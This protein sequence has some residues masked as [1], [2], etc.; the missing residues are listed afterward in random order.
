MKTST[1]AA[2]GL[3]LPSATVAGPEGVDRV[4]DPD[5]RLLPAQ[6]TADLEQATDVAR[7]HRLR[8]R[9][10]D[11]PRLARAEVVRHG[12]LRD[13]VAAG[14]ATAQFALRQRDEFPAGD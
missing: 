2:C 3:A 9:R 6:V 12:R 7:E 11:V 10:Q 13:V 8:A 14:G 5:V 4:G 1:D